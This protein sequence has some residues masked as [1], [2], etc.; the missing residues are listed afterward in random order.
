M[1]RFR[2][3]SSSPGGGGGPLRFI[4]NLFTTA[5]RNWTRIERKKPLLA[6]I[7]NVTV[8]EN[9][10]VTTP[11]ITVIEGYT[12]ISY[13]LVNAP[14]GVQ[15]NS[16]TGAVKWPAASGVGVR[17]VT[18]RAFNRYG[19]T[20]AQFTIT[21]TAAP[22][23]A[24]AAPD[25]VPID[26]ATITAG[27]AYTGPTP[28][29]VNAAPATWTLEAGP[30][31]M[32]INSLGVVSWPE[33][34]TVGSPHTVTIKATN[35]TSDD[36]ETWTLTVNPAPVAPTLE[37]LDDDTATAPDAYTGP[38][39]VG[40]GDAPLVY[41]LLDAP[42]GMTIDS[43][44]GVVSWPAS[45]HVGSPHLI[46]V[47]LSG[48]SGTTPAVE[49]FLLTV[50]PAPTQPVIDPV[51]DMLACT[52]QAFTAPAL[53]ASETV[54]WTLAVS[55]VGM[56]I[57]ALSGVISWPAPAAGVH[58]VVARATDNEDLYDEVTF[59]VTVRRPPVITPVPDGRMIAGKPFAFTLTLTQ[60][61]GPI[62]WTKL[63]G[64]AGLT[65]T[66]SGDTLRCTLQWVSATAGTHIIEI[67]AENACDDTTEVS[68]LTVDPA[69]Q[70]PTPPQIATIGP[71]QIYQGTGAWAGFTPTATGTQP[72]TWS[73]MAG[74]TGLTV[75]STT[76]KPAWPIPT[77]GAHP[78]TLRCSGTGYDDESFTLTVLPVR[79]SD[80]F[81]GMCSHAITPSSSDPTVLA[82]W[83]SY[84]K[85]LY[86]SDPQAAARLNTTLRALGVL[87]LDWMNIHG[88][89]SPSS[90]CILK[91]GQLGGLSHFLDALNAASKYYDS[92][93][94]FA[95]QMPYLMHLVDATTRTALQAAV[96]TRFETDTTTGPLFDGAFFD[97]ATRTPIATHD[98]LVAVGS[99]LF[100]TRPANV[101]DTT[102]SA[103]L[104]IQIE[105][106]VALAVAAWG[107]NVRVLVNVGRSTFQSIAGRDWLASLPVQCMF[108]CENYET[109][110]GTTAKTVI[111]TI[112]FL[113]HDI[114]FTAHANISPTQLGQLIT[115][116]SLSAF[117][118]VA[119]A[120]KVRA[121]GTVR[122]FYVGIQSDAASRD[123]T[124]GYPGYAEI[125]RVMAGVNSVTALGTPGSTS[126]SITTSAG[127]VSINYANLPMV[128]SWPI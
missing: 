84:F 89:G 85:L 101:T 4:G 103:A 125:Q 20:D 45:T 49:S 9:A 74:P 77:V 1:P 78:I 87:I 118:A 37:P 58:T 60:G 123:T 23:P 10:A 61:D 38:T 71:V 25:I 47:Q 102:Y 67:K 127:V 76:G 19:E 126:A 108:L 5:G 28:Q 44:T 112:R 32:T 105:A 34:T 15:V 46:T 68:I 11:A 50:D 109:L 73:K 95:S 91:A 27:S 53:T 86:Q 59:T 30:A 124:A 24:P 72:F 17:N 116:R 16:S 40:A 81:A 82:T 120:G 8:Q 21:V 12:P 106:L 26:N 33:P 54:G 96:E 100:T 99:K 3:P 104:K 97:N 80:C 51:S 79:M 111:E 18:I 48:A 6:A 88:C 36:T 113:N 107:P 114:A 128:G 117:C 83:A 56:T 22:V 69:T 35:P 110:S 14:P 62:T 94:R 93:G 55:P 65:L 7:D 115:H 43:T 42:V 98:S 119:A 57:N 92:A 70:P 64:P 29:L 63:Q 31:G 41:A 39:P 66:P 90:V 122:K 52:G 121:D 75:S 2:L 13:A